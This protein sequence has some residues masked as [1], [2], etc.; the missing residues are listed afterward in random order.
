MTSVGS[1][2]SLFT[3]RMPGFRCRRD[4]CLNFTFRRKPQNVCPT[5]RPNW[6]GHHRLPL[7]SRSGSVVHVLS[8][9]LR[10]KS[11]PPLPAAVAAVVP[12]GICPVLTGDVIQ[13]HSPS[14]V[15]HDGAVAD[16]DNSD[17]FM[18]GVSAL[19]C[20]RSP[21]STVDYSLDAH[22]NL[23]S[24]LWD[25][26][27]FLV[28]LCGHVDACYIVGTACHLLQRHRGHLPG[29]DD[30]VMVA[31]I[32][33]IAVVIASPPHGYN[34]D[35]RGLTNL[36]LRDRLRCVIAGRPFCHVTSVFSLLVCNVSCLIHTAFAT[37]F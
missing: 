9:R 32:L 34:F 20:V 25:Q 33:S 11:K 28:L 12:V 8:R 30:L 24:L 27:S 16:G 35:L 21:A 5:C 22:A 10:M 23:Q 15:S 17:L 36:D 19:H 6:R 3:V 14:T 2:F 13:T 31:A 18:L 37:Y 7:P 29:C 4:G 1:R 26:M